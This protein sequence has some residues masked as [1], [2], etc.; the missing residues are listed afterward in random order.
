[1]AQVTTQEEKFDPDGQ[2]VRSEQTNES[3]AHDNQG[4]SNT[5]ATSASTNVPGG[6]STNSTTGGAGSDNSGNESTT[7]YEI[8]KTVT[9]QVL[10]PGTVKR[11]SVAVAVDGVTAPGKD[12]KP[13]PYTARTPEEMQHITDLV[14]AAMGFTD[15]GDRHDQVQ[16]VN[17]QFPSA[18]DG[19]GTTAASGMNFDKND[20]MRMIELGV[21][22]L[23]ALLILFFVLRPMI[24]SALQ[25]A[26]AAGGGGETALLP[27]GS[28]ASVTTRAVVLPDGTP[29][30]VTIDNATGQPL[31]LPSPIGAVTDAGI[32]IARIEGQVKASSV[33]RV[34]EFVDKH[35]E[36]SVAILRTWLHESA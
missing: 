31:A 12:G 10:Q 28:S 15:A 25:G 9:T 32:D 1:M 23:V 7:N 33:K 16:V 21:M 29:A 17:E 24:R 19:D 34:A 8:S 13:G 18:Q 36:E 35:P 5:G 6:T 30:T 11:L 4:G 14:K 2:V 22:G 26:S 3:T 20:I 27:G